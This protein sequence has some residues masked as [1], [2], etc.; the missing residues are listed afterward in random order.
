MPIGARNLITGLGV[1]TSIG[2]GADRFA[3]GLRRGSCGIRMYEDPSAFAAARLDD[4]DPVAFI[5]ALPGCP[6]G[7]RSRAKSLWRRSTQSAR[8]SAAAAIEAWLDAIGEE[9]AGEPERTGLVAAGNNINKQYQADGAWQY[10]QR[11]EY[12]SPRHAFLSLDTHAMSQISELLGIL[13]FGLNIGASSASGNA[14]LW[15]ALQLLRSGEVDRVLVCGVSQELS[16]L[17]R[18]A[19]LNIGAMAPATCSTDPQKLYRPFD[20]ASTGFVAGEGAACVV[21]E[22]AEAAVARGASAWAVLSGASLLL[23]GSHLPASDAEGERRAMMRALERAALTPE[24]IDMVNAH[25]SGSRQGD[26]VECQAIG[27]AF[28]ESGPWVNSTKSLVGHCL[29]SAGLVEAAACA[30]Q[31][32]DGFVHPNRNLDCPVGAQL[33]FAGSQAVQAQVRNVI[34]N[35]FGFGGINSSVILSHPDGHYPYGRQ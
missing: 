32:R 24:D 14:A 35:S 26:A 21:L 18:Q 28:G 9:V 30:L 2:A 15:T 20:K 25:G 3:E 27:D 1:V 4:F 31:I 8:I 11:P 23:S 7:L 16:S 22:T 13:G 34:S 29:T 10:E 19:Y 5:A 33:R 6:K 17:E 12:L